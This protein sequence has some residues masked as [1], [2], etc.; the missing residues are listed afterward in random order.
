MDQKNLPSAR[1]RSNTGQR[2]DRAVLCGVLRLKSEVAKFGFWVPKS[3][4][5]FLKVGFFSC[6]IIVG[7]R[8]EARRHRCLRRRSKTTR[9]ISEVV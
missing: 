1:A 6:T 3:D 2:E 7:V 4:P 9:L 5:I 8:M